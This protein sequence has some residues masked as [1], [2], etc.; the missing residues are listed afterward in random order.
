ME[1]LAREVVRRVQS[2]RRDA[3]FEIDDNIAIVYTASERLAKAIEKF[4][5]YIKAET[6]ALHLERGEPNQAYHREAFQPDDDPK[7]DTSI[8]GE[9]LSLG[10]RRF[11]KQSS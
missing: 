10:V 6:L 4:A 5:D 11:E 3:D 9:S 8:K 2:M 7:K 1:G